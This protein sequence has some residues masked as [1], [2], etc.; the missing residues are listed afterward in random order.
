M[1][2]PHRPQ[3]PEGRHGQE[4]AGVRADRDPAGV[5]GR[6]RQ[7]RGVWRG[8]ALPLA[9]DH[10]R[11]S[12]RR[13]V[14]VPR[15]REGGLAAAHCL[16]ATVLRPGADREVPRHLADATAGRQGPAGQRAAQP[17]A[18]GEQP[19]AARQRRLGAAS[20]TVGGGLAGTGRHGRA[21]VLGEDRPTTLRVDQ[22]CLHHGRVHRRQPQLRHHLGRQRLPPDADAAGLPVRLPAHDDPAGRAPTRT[23]TS[24]C[25]AR[26]STTSNASR[27]NWARSS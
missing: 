2:R 26:S 15:V 1:E 16:R 18:A 24:T 27:R 17:A 13:L 12:V 4:E 10:V 22:G 19:V 21:L 9:A 6:G 5:A 3:L 20:R 7:D 11:H 8:A 14:G 25:S 23:C